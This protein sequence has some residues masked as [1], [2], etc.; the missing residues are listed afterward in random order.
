L[1]IY[2]G[3]SRGA[4]RSVALAAAPLISDGD[5]PRRAPWLH[6][7]Y[8]RAINIRHPRV[9]TARVCQFWNDL[10]HPELACRMFVFFSNGIG[11]AGS[12]LVS[13]VLTLLLLYTCSGP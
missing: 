10:G 11:I 8:R 3:T 1:D 7:S 2:L 6:S 9:A 4:S 12:I 5:A 13:I